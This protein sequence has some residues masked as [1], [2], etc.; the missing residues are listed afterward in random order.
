MHTREINLQQNFLC[1]LWVICY[2]MNAFNRMAFEQALK[3][4]MI[5][6]GRS[7]EAPVV[8]RLFDWAIGLGQAHEDWPEDMPVPGS[9]HGGS[10]KP[11]AFSCSRFAIVS[12][13]VPN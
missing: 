13:K 8:N 7:P 1:Y 6:L 4:Q 2:C 12:K 5:S 3:H 9:D 11:T 10:W